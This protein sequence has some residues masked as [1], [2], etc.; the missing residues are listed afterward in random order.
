MYFYK[1]NQTIFGCFCILFI[2][3]PN[4]FPSRAG[5]CSGAFMPLTTDDEFLPSLGEP[6]PGPFVT[7]CPETSR[8]WRRIC[9]F[10]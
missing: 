4:V 7:G 8:A 6:G 5:I 2:N 10:K 1:I 3:N 9:S